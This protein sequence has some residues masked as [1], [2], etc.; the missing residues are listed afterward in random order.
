M[1]KNDNPLWL[2]DISIDN[3]HSTIILGVDESLYIV[4][5]G[6]DDSLEYYQYLIL[7]NQENDEIKVVLPEGYVLNE[8]YNLSD[9]IAV[10]GI[11]KLDT[12]DLF[13]VELVDIIEHIPFDE[14]FI[15]FDSTDEAIS[16]GD[17][18][19]TYWRNAV[20]N[21]D[22]VCKCCGGHKYLEAHH[23]FSWEDYPDLRLDVD[24]GVALC[25]WCHHKYNSY[26]GH[27]GSGINLV[28]F[29]IK[30]GVR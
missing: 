28:E 5:F 22:K 15:D 16:R 25:K 7:A 18:R 29:L 14:G 6:Y 27:K 1:N 4:D 13:Y 21:R 12:I 3:L 19:V 8:D 10:T 2:N 9:N 17:S 24:N 26:F 30:F 11:L 23:I 20:L